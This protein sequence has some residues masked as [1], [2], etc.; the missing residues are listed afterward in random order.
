MNEKLRFGVVRIVF[1]VFP[2]TTEML[3]VRMLANS[4]TSQ[5]ML[6]PLQS[7]SV[8]PMPSVSVASF[9]FCRPFAQADEHTSHRK[10]RIAVT[11]K[12]WETKRDISASPH[13]YLRSGEISIYTHKDGPEVRVLVDVHVA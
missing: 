12:S 8:L 9:T 13:S 2:L 3:R 4:V 10:T 7:A 6:L 11:T 5:V 1:A